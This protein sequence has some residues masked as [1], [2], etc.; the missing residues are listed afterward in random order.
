LLPVTVVHRVLDLATFSDS[1]VSHSH[2]CAWGWRKFV[3]WL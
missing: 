3:P 2:L 1:K